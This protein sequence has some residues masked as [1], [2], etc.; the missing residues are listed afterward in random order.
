MNIRKAF[1]LV[2]V[3]SCLAAGM[4]MHG[5]AR[6]AGCDI[7]Q[8]DIDA[9]TAVRNDPT[10]D[11]LAAVKAELAIRKELVGRTIG[12]AEQE[13]LG[14]QGVLAAAPAVS[15][16]DVL[17][18]QLGDKLNESL[19]F[20]AIERGKLLTAGIAG[21]QAVAKELLAWRNNSWSV[22]AGQVSNFVLWSNNQSLFDTARNRM[23]QT[24][25]TAAFL[26]GISANIGLETAVNTARAAMNAANGTNDAAK[27]ALLQFLPPDQSL[28]LIK[29]SLEGLSLTYKDFSAVNDLM[30]QLL[31]Q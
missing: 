9:I 8:S 7:A 22:V 11:P 30:K 20:Y 28:V 31:P 25:R 12:C 2:M 10:L 3:F 26:D 6:A 15:G 4:L 19:N 13:A 21:S 17:R 24:G 23:D 5:V 1:A 29:Q 14:L 16:A 18:S 27:S